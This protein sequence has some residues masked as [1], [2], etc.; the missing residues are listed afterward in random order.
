MTTGKSRPFDSPI[1]N[2]GSSP[3][4]IISFN[5]NGVRSAARKGFFDWFAT[6]DAD[7]LCMQETKAQEHQLA[8]TD[9]SEEH[10]SE[11]QSLMRISYAVFCLKNQNERYTT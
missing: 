6:Q 7:L 5:A 8:G 11:L 9:R 4:R 2:P 10:T 1:P 3:M